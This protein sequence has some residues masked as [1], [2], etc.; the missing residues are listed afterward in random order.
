[1]RRIPQL[2]ALVW[3]VGISF[4]LLQVPMYSSMS[5]SHTVSMH[6]SGLS[7]AP[8]NSQ[9][10]LL[11]VNGPGVLRSLAIPALLA[12]LALL[13]P[14]QICS[15]VAGTAAVLVGLYSVLGAMTVGLYYAPAALLL[16]VAALWRDRIRAQPA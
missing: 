14:P 6:G 5:T 16:L 1:M 11:D 3:C 12:L 9:T 4:Y 15:R 10:T 13:A 8:A 7:S 2:L